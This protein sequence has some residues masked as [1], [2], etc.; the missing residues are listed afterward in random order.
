MTAAVR[1]VGLRQAFGE[2]VAVD[3]VDLDV[4]PGEIFGLLGPNGAG[5]TT[6]IR[7]ITTLLPAPRRRD[8]GVRARRRPAP[9]GGAAPA[10]LR[11]PAAV[12][13]RPLTGRENVAL[14]ARLFDVPRRERAARVDEA[15]DADGPRRRRRPARRDLLG[16]HGAPA[17]AGAGAGQPPPA[18]DPRRADDR[19]RP[20]G[21]RRRVGAHRRAP[22]ADRHDRARHH[23]LHGGGRGALRPGR[24]DAPRPHPGARHPG[25]A[26]GARSGPT[27]RST[28]SSAAYTGDTLAEKEE[29]CAMSVLPAAPPVASADARCTPRRG[30]PRHG[31]LAG[32]A[33]CAWSS[34]RSSATTA[35]S[36]SPGPSSPRCGCSIFGETFTRLHAIPTG[37]IPYLD[38]LAPGILAQSALFVAIFYGIQVIWERDAGVLAKLLVTP[39]T[40]GRA[41]HRRRRSRR[42]SGRSRRRSSCCVLALLLGVGLSANPLQLARRRSWRCC[43][44]RRSS[45]ACR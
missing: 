26:Q 20:G 24:A 36:W 40:A 43:S 6:T 39:D 14:F 10:G 38:Y 7:L 19:A 33:R 27:P 11:A 37:D 23:P 21:P 34:C 28:T 4:E 2:T 13:R 32:S 45:A 5:K 29:S 8:R 1:C 31:G 42:A 22:R 9:D 16:R 17:R 35:P 15:L 44:A 18:A 41:R 25:R 30:R 12:G 3:G